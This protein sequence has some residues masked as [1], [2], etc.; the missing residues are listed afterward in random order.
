[1]RANFKRLK[2]IILIL[3]IAFVAMTAAL[4]FAIDRFNISP[5]QLAPYLA[6]RADGHNP[7]I[8]GTANWLGQ[9]ILTLDRGAVLTPLLQT[10]P[11]SNTLLIGAQRQ[12]QASRSAF[13]PKPDPGAIVLVATP[14]EFIAAIAHARGGD[15]ITFMPGTYRFEGIGYLDINQ[16]GRSGEP[17]TVRAEQPDTVF[18]EFNMG[19]GF[20]VLAPYWTFENLHI[21]GVCKEQTFCEHAFHIVGKASHFIARNNTII[22]FNAHF[23][24]NGEERDFPDYGLID[25]NTLSNSGARQTD[26]P[27]TLIDLVAASHW[28]ISHNL[29]ADF[30]KAQGDQIS[31]GAFVKGAGADNRMEQNIVLCEHLL[32]GFPG[33]RVGLSLGGGGTGKEYC[34]DRRCITEQDGGVIQSN[35]IAS[36]SDEGIYL[37]RA[38]TSKVLHNTLIDTG[39]MSVRFVE[40]SADMEGNLIDGPVRTREGGL[41]RASDNLITG[42]PRLY[43][44][45]HPVRDLF[46]DTA[47][48]NFTWKTR[49]PVR[50]ALDD[51]IPD[52]CSASRS[53]HP[54]Y[55]A[56]E[57]FSACLTH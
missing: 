13:T 38:A 55:G 43:L 26:R 50:E 17:I 19:E 37:N 52:L 23:K 2:K 32:H 10:S 36:C 18:L 45:L 21:R 54:S 42:A 9:K 39:G 57:D 14:A 29:I 6:H 46:A 28:R 4:A 15:V 34:R 11:S 40:S 33:Q 41:L 20:K 27:V 22:D 24:I 8:V 16:A 47:A 48:M 53:R 49:P 44:G 31:Y 51:A 25:G 35:L 3:V 5:R 30:I 1:M 56:F 7:A 12:A